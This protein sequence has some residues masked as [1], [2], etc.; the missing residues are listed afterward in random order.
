MRAKYLCLV[1]VFAS[2]AVGLVSSQPPPGEGKAKGKIELGRVFPPPLREQLKLTPEQAKEL[3]TIEKELKTNLDKL[4]TTEQKKTIEGFVGGPPGQGGPGGKG[5]PPGQG[6]PG[7]KKGGAMVELGPNPQAGVRANPRVTAHGSLKIVGDTAFPFTITG[8]VAESILGDSRLEHNGGGVRLLSGEDTNKDGKLA[9]EATCTIAGVKDEKGRWYRVRVNGLAQPDFVVE[10]DELYLKVE[11]FKDSGTNSLDFIKKSI[12]PQVELDRKSL[13]DPQT[14][15]NLG[16]ATW[17]TFSIDVRTPFVEVDTLKVS[18]GFANGV[19]KG[20]KSEFWFADVDVMPIP[21]P[22]D[23]VAP[24]KPATDKN[25][26]ALANLVKLGGRWYFDP[27]GGDKTPPKQFDHTNVDRLY[28]L[29]DR[30]ETP[31]VGNVSAW[32]RKGYLDLAGKMVEK[33]QYLE[34]SVTIAFTET[35]LVMNSKNLPNHPVSLFPDQTRSLD[36]NPGRIREKA[37]IWRIPLEPKLNPNRAAAITLEKQDGL[38]MG[39][40]GVAVNGVVFFNPFDAPGDD[41]VK[42]L[43]R[44]CGHPGPD[45]LYHYHKYPVCINTPWSEDGTAHSPLIGFAFDGFPVYGPY[46]GKGVLAKD[47]KD[48]PLNDFN[49]HTD[50]ACGPHYHVTPGQFPHIIGGYWGTPERGGKKGPPKK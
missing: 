37:N 15:K 22:A 19:G 3:E 48:N 25:P 50:D 47:S 14:N 33:D 49:L 46:E 34:N 38:P 41:A 31:F 9:G 18:V 45:S 4:L 23:Y 35:H 1:F 36:G 32:L 20:K 13:L 11:F 17:R 6:G 28:Y 39:P 10:K 44:C 26:P 29:T 12:Y 16:P 24:A 2:L 42:R 30:L 8:D 21:D 5:G 27:R 7:G 40:I 43:D